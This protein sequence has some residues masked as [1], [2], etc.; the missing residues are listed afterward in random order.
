MTS[1]LSTLHCPQLPPT[2]HRLRQVCELPIAMLAC[3]RIGAVHSVVFG[4][5]SAEALG[6]GRMEGWSCAGLAPHA[7]CTL[8]EPQ[9]T[10]GAKGGAP[11]PGASQASL[12]LMWARSP[13][14]VARPPAP[15]TAPPNHHPGRIA[16]CQAKVL[17]TASGVMRGSKRIDLKAIADKG[18]ELAAKEGHTV[19]RGGPGCVGAGVPT[20]PHTQHPPNP[21]KAKRAPGTQI[22]HT[23][24]HTHTL[25]HTRTH[26][27][28]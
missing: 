21:R 13:P 2:F 1:R 20:I 25:R 11:H 12:L 8:F 18:V 23:H 6:G 14:D 19:G 27:H 3:A 15:P 4:G 17:I 16:D 22:P 5:F 9:T 28:T 10:H 7:R 24:T 26:G